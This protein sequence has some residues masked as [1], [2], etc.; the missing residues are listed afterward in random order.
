MSPDDLDDAIQKARVAADAEELA[1]RELQRQRAEEA[2]RDA[3]L[4]R[5]YDVRLRRL[6]SDFVH[7]AR[8]AGIKPEKIDFFVRHRQKTGIFGGGWE[9]EYKTVRGWVVPDQLPAYDARGTWIYVLDDG[10]IV[11]GDGTGV[12]GPFAG[13][14]QQCPP[15]D[16]EAALQ[17]IAA[18]IARFLV[19][20]GA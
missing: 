13:N 9:S 6:G 12:L 11:T 16:P 8:N 19:D 14:R 15:A 10:S 3:R 18:K 20:R 4:L 17:H 1:Q 7:R 5:E 2:A